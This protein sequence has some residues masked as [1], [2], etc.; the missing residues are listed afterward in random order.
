M[1]L[2]ITVNYRGVPSVQM[3]FRLHEGSW[4]KSSALTMYM[5]PQCA[6]FQVMKFRSTT[7]D[8][9]KLEEQ[10]FAQE[11]PGSHNAI[12]TWVG[13]ARASKGASFWQLTQQTTADW[14]WI[15]GD[16]MYA[17]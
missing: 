4:V 9:Q 17:C 13:E 12:D 7:P 16:P 15:V 5:H 3:P 6:G 14:T 1:D 8:Q 2:N 11:P 10:S